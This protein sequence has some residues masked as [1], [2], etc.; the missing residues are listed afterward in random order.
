MRTKMVAG[1]WKMNMTLQEGVALATELKNQVVNP[2]CAVVIG[3][4][5]I[6][7]ATVAELLKDSPIAVAAENCAD[8]E[9]GAYTGEVSA[10]MVAS[11]GAEYCIL[12][13]S[14]RRAY[15]GETYEILKDKVELALANN[16]RPI[17]CIGEV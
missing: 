17:F 13:H 3:T 10:A 9:K 1:N 5:F 8:K 6:H 14:E 4:P 2:S 16:L 7:L 15:Y 11:T 12:G